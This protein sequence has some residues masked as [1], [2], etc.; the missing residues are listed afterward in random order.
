MNFRSRMEKRLTFV[1][2]SGRRR[3]AAKYRLIT[4][5]VMVTIAVIGFFTG[6]VVEERTLL[7]RMH[8]NLPASVLA[9]VMISPVSHQ[10]L[11]VAEIFALPFRDF[12]EALRSAPAEAREKWAD[13]LKAMP[14]GP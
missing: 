3:M 13:E 14:E 6:R 9:P 2:S 11:Q 1:S 10:Q 8:S 12:Y 5:I 4:A 7:E